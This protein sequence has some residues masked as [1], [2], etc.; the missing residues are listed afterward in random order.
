MAAQGCE[1]DWTLSVVKL[2]GLGAEV[3]R[4]CGCGSVQA[5]STLLIAT[6]EVIDWVLFASSC[7]YQK[8][9]RA[10]AQHDLQVRGQEYAWCNQEGHESSQ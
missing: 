5:C 10:L 7:A 9:F 3:V 2:L 4:R 1:T 6:Q 8:W